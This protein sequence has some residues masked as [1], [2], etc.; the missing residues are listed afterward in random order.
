MTH[1]IKAVNNTMGGNYPTSKRRK[2]K[3]RVMERR[4]KGV[5]RLVNKGSDWLVSCHSGTSDRTGEFWQVDNSPVV[6]QKGTGPPGFF[7][8]CLMRHHTSLKE[9]GT[10][11][12]DRP[13]TSRTA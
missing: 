6:I 5:G 10:I 1:G 4:D 12:G 7:S 2:E 13:R 11:Y 3:R 9:Q 8:V